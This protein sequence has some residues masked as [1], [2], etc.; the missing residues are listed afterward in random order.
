MNEASSLF[1]VEGAEAHVTVDLSVGH[2]HELVL[3]DGAHRIAPLHTAPWVDDPAVCADET[4][5]PNVR[6]LSGDFLCGP[7]G[8][9]D[10]E[11]A[12][13][14]GWPANSAWT[15]EDVTTLAGE[16]AV[17][18]RFRLERQVMGAVVFKELTLRNGH[19]FLYQRH[20]FIGGSGALPVSNHAMVRWRDAEISFSDKRFI[21]TPRRPV[22][23]DPARG[24]S[25]LCYPQEIGPDRRATTRD[26]A[27]IDITS[28][29]FADRHEDHIVL[30]ESAQSELGWLAL[31]Q[32]DSDWMFLSLKNA[33]QHPFT[34]LWF[35]NGGRD[36]APWSGRHVGVIGIEEG[37]TYA[38]YGHAA[39]I[40]DNEYS[41]LGVPT[42]FT[43]VPGA[44]LDLRH[45]IG[46]THWPAGCG[47][48][49]AVSA[50]EDHLVAVDTA[51]RAKRWRFDRRFLFP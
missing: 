14:H 42:S 38:G 41:D 25:A 48:V 16:G 7:F 21:R 4:I 39:S 8:R 49:Q 36:Y 20:L 22:E 35:S 12:P 9:S 3:C 19:P 47:Q 5:L 50:E 43:L 11:P 1:K 27:S 37:R 17:R 23:S 15:I 33:H 10:V 34:N 44:T 2:L 28:L 6:R 31:R 32:R 45:V 30:T 46:A 18:A 29:P 51:R 26:G 40:A 13:V 24:R